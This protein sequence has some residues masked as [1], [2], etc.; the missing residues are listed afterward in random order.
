MPVGPV[1]ESTNQHTRLG[2]CTIH[3]PSGELL[4]TVTFRPSADGPAPLRRSPAQAAPRP[5]P[6]QGGFSIGMPVP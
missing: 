5:G 3:F 2:H 4:D 6:S 1:D